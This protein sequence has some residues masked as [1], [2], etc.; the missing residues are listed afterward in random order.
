[1]KINFI[2]DCYDHKLIKMEQTNTKLNVADMF[3]KPVSISTFNVLVDLLKMIVFE[4]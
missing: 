1:M 3:T 2:R 4:D